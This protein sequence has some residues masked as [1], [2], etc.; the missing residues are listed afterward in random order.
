MDRR[1]FVPSPEGLEGRALLSLFGHSTPAQTTSKTT[2]LFG[3]STANDNIPVTFRQKELRVD[4]VP[5]YLERIR[6]GRFLPNDTLTQ[7]QTDLRAVTGTLHWPGPKGLE[8]F[9][10]VQREISGNSSLSA[11]DAHTLSRSFGAAVKATGATPGEVT[12]LQADLNDLTRVDTNSPQPTFLATNDYALVLETILGIGR[13]I[14]RPTTPVLKANTGLRLNVNDGVTGHP[15]P[16][17]VGT[18]SAVQNSTS[19]KVVASNT[20]MEI[21]DANDKVHGSAP[22]YNNGDYSVKIDAPLSPGL[23]TFYVRAVDNQGHMSNFS[24]PYKLKIIPNK[25]PLVAAENL[26]GPKGPKALGT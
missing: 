6:P 8:E 9:N 7:L 5:Y 19:T 13:P 3:T 25:H 16:T 21:V 11:T 26:S 15:E 2:S 4:H 1:R 18:Y 20:S 24:P 10:H 14:Q 22:I 17:L 12:N 23:Y